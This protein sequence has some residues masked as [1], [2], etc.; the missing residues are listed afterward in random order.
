M[1]FNRIINKIIVVLIGCCVYVTPEIRAQNQ[2]FQW[3]E[4]SVDESLPAGFTSLTAEET[5]IQFKNALASEK[6]LMNQVYLNGSGVALGDVDGNGFCDIYFCGLD[7]ANQ[8]YLN[9][10]GWKFKEVAKEYGVDCAGL[11]STG[12]ALVDLDGD[13]DLDLLNAG[14]GS[15]NVVWYENTSK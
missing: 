10:G 12:A 7:S 11:D 1:W 15:A 14:R 13:G 3:S 4:L 2:P 6:S 8:L 5:G 9:E